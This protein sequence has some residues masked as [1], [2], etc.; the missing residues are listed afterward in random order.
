MDVK[1]QEAADF[2]AREHRKIID[3]WC[4]AYLAEIYQY[5]IDIKPGCFIL[6]EQLDVELKNGKMGKKYWFEPQDKKENSNEQ[7]VKILIQELNKMKEYIE[8]QLIILDTEIYNDQFQAKLILK[9]LKK[10]TNFLDG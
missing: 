7:M 10:M 1:L 4:K 5:G 2:I 6:V 8:E 9:Q 3:D